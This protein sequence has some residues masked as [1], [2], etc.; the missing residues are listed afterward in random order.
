MN[1]CSINRLCRGPILLA[2]G[3]AAAAPLPVGAQD[4]R[5]LETIERQ[6][7]SS[8]EV[9]SRI[10]A[11]IAAAMEEQDEV[12]AR[13]AEATA[14][15]KAQ[16]AAIA[17]S[18]MEL[19][20]LA[21]DRVLLL[22]RLGEKQDVLSELLAGLQRLDRNPPPALVVRPDDVL[23]A[24]RGAMLLGV[25]IPELAQEADTLAAEL[26]RLREV[27]A[28]ITRRKADLAGEVA[29][30]EAT[31]KDLDR[32]L[33]AKKSL[34]KRSQ[35][36]LEAEQKRIAALSE[37]ARNLK[38]L[39]ADLAAA[40]EREDAEAAARMAAEEAERK[41][42]E[43]LHRRPRVDFAE[44][45]GRLELP[46][47]GDILRRF[48]DKTAVGGTAQGLMI[49]TR[50]KA[51]V[52]TPAD[53]KVEFAGPFRSYGQLVILNPGSG[54]RV[55]LAGMDTVTVTAGE[56]LR[57][58]EPIGEMGDGP[59]SVTLFGDVVQEGRPVLYIEFRKST[60]V[61]DS[62]PWWAGGMREARG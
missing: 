56:F 42:L 27:E 41:R 60:E 36:D 26:D 39:L 9:S 59:A 5:Q 61:I 49:A 16:E 7:G 58:G 40:R 15:I 52:T 21:E 29:R 50:K 35:S 12:A 38:Q 47:Q 25:I 28:R 14:A 4:A 57:A 48:G 44:A 20:R 17:A 51:V 13:L 54:Y 33:A 18:E 62:G 22:A 55:L 37:K 31:R 3:L 8:R 34:V 23:A 11:E 1:T 43:D 32:L 19:A 53:G 45:R 24:L 2:L 10:A 6:I 30:L 46:V